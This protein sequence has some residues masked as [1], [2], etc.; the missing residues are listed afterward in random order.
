[1]AIDRLGNGS[2]EVPA[3]GS[4]RATTRL[5]LAVVAAGFVVL[6]FLFHIHF[7]LFGIG[8]WAA[9]VLTAALVVVAARARD[10]ERA[11]PTLA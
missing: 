3:I 10:A 6:K 7:S 5:V 1:L 9:V 11:V 2:V 8:F 4:S